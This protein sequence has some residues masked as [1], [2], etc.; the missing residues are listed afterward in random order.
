MDNLA[1]L[2]EQLIA[3]GFYRQATMRILA[4]LACHVLVTLVGIGLLIGSDSLACHLIGMLL[5]TIGSFGVATNTHTS[6]HY[7]TSRTPWVNECLTYFGYPF[8]WQLSATYWRYKHITLHHSYPN[9]IGIDRDISLHPWFTLTQKNMS[10]NSRLFHLYYRYQWLFFPFALTAN[11]YNS[12]FKG[13]RHLLTALRRP[14]R[15]ASN[16]IDLGTLIL[17]WISWIIVPAMFLPL[18]HVLL[19]YN[20]R[21]ILMGYAMFFVFAPAHFP[22]EAVAFRKSDADRDFVL[23]QTLATLNFRV[24]LLGRLTF[25]GL[26]YHIEHHLFPGISHVYYPQI[27]GL[28]REFCEK[29]GYPYRTLDWGK[30]LLKSFTV[31]RDL[32]PIADKPGKVTASLLLKHDIP[33]F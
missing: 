15:T 8:F 3:K 21:N 20:L 16:W 10:S 4:E 32:K 25:S 17:H 27:S 24:G 11:A 30:G 7:A 6:S 2:R 9:T 23:R 13:W 22:S 14:S 29:H 19:F 18:S 12:Q 33:N 26:N 1:S 31:L 5:A 28:V